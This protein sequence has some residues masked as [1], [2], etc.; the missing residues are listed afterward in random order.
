MCLAYWH[1]TQTILTMYTKQS[2]LLTKMLCYSSQ[3][4]TLSSRCI[5]SIIRGSEQS[6]LSFSTADSSQG[7]VHVGKVFEASLMTLSI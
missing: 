2:I 6:T 1:Q 5:D 3:S 7:T 4:N